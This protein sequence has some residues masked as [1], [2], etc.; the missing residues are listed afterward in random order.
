[1][2][3]NRKRNIYH[4]TVCHKRTSNP[5]AG[6]CQDC[7]N[8]EHNIAKLDALKNAPEEAGL[9]A[10]HYERIRAEMSEARRA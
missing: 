8:N 5:K 7:I 2:S 3:V 1:M 9:S 4:C 10:A 6:L